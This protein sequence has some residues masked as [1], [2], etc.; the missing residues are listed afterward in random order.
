MNEKRICYFIVEGLGN[1]YKSFHLIEET[2][3]CGTV[4]VADT[5]VKENV[6]LLVLK[7]WHNL[8]LKNKIKVYWA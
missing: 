1:R 8:L 6:E 2:V 4:L 7:D 3:S 5:F